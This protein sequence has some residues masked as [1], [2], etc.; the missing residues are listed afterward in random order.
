MALCAKEG[1][2][3]IGEQVV[4]G[5]PMG[6]MTAGAVNGH[7]GVPRILDIL[8]QGMGGMC[9]VIVTTGAD[10]PLLLFREE[11]PILGAVR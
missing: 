9:F 7:I 10:F 5:C 11:I 1:I 4:I 8:S 6:T 3:G 2:G